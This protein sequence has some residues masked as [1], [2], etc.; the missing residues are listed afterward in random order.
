LVFLE[1]RKGVIEA[2]SLS[3]LTAAKQ[4]GGQV[5]ALVVG[6]SEHVNGVVE[7]A[8]KWVSPSLPAFRGLNESLDSKA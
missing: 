6:D 2:G 5:S 4:L 1:H 3:A 8:K 7:Q